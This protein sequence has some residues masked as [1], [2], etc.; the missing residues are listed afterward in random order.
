MTEDTKGTLGKGALIG[1]VLHLPGQLLIL[2]LQGFVWSET[3]AGVLLFAGFTQVVYMVPAAI[4]FGVR[5]QWGIAKGILL[6]MGIGILLT[7]LC[8]ALVLGSIS[9]H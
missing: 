4:V 3:G 2:L 8:T 9:Y 6:V 7:G 5:R 1:L